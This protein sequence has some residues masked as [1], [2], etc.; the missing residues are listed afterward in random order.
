MTILIIDDHS[1]FR[2]SSAEILRL[3]GHEVE[4]AATLDEARTRLS[5]GGV[6]LVIF[7]LGLG[8]GTGLDVLD[9]VEPPPPVI[10]V[11]GSSGSSVSDPRIALFLS[12][13]V[14]PETLIEKVAALLN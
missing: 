5:R 2:R 10:L 8:A 13:P 6:S 3:N 12:K 4:E 14:V 7:D 11:S 9:G 1:G